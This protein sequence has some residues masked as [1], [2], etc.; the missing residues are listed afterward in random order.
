VI[1]RFKTR[2]AE[3]IR[4][5][6][7]GLVMIVDR[8]GR[9]LWHHGRP[10]S[11]RTVDEGRGFSRS[12]LL[13]VIEGRTTLTQ[14]DVMIT[15]D[16]RSL[17]ESARLLLV[18]S[19]LVHTID[20]HLVLYVDS[21]NDAFGRE[22][23]EFFT[24]NSTALK[25]ILDELRNL[26]GRDGGITGSSP[27]AHRM[28]QLVIA[29]AVEDD[30]VLLLGETGVGKSHIAQMIHRFS[31]RGGQFIIVDTPALPESLFESEL[32]GHKRGTFT[33]A[34]RDKK[35]LVEAAE[36]GTLFFDEV[37][38]VPMAFQA[39]LLRLIDTQRFRALG[40]TVDRSAAVRIIAAT[41]RDLEEEI[42]RKRFRDDLFFRLDVL[43]IE[44][45]PLRDR[46]EDIRTLIEEHEHFLRGKALGEGFWD[47]VLSYD[48]PGNAR[49]LINL[50][51]RAGIILPGP[52]IGSE[53]AELLARRGT[54]TRGGDLRSGIVARLKAEIDT[55]AS[56]WDSAWAAFLDRE[57][58]RDQLRDLLAAYYEECDHSLKETAR[59]LNI[60]KAR[61]PR[62][63]SA[64]HKY[65][66]HPGR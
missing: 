51:K 33:G 59:R 17:P 52:V 3:K 38:E 48:W 32:F 4:S 2:L 40:D 16:E 41:N 44:I 19:L 5:K 37:A 66:V 22:D 57:I 13:K 15:G 9:I 46:R 47:V 63:V 12:G 28:R 55:G 39:K 10:V 56:F 62:F 54:P 20:D 58:N 61:Y 26:E 34:E 50:M 42:A 36:G 18:K 64:L 53:I 25:A 11:G 1:E 6:E 29:Y 35:G 30:P 24:E 27:A 45:P 8:S 7:I 49:E 60:G 65:R 31:S 23:I 43:S 21:G 14:Q